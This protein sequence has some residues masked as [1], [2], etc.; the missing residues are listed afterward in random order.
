MVVLLHR[1]RSVWLSASRGRSSSTKNAAMPIM[2]GRC[3]RI[4][5]SHCAGNEAPQAHDPGDDFARSDF[6]QQQIALKLQFGEADIDAIDVV[7]DVTDKDEGDDRQDRLLENDGFRFICRNRKTPGLPL[8]NPVPH[9]PR[10]ERMVSPAFCFYIRRTA[11]RRRPTDSLAPASA[12]VLRH[13][14]AGTRAG[15]AFWYIPRRI[16]Q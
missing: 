3:L 11:A 6:L 12:S 2:T 4:R 1:R 9:A 7:Q 8:Q 14:R 5:K 10:P 13:I 16:A 15:R